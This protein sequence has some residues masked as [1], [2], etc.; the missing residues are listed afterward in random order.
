[1][2]ERELE[3]L[4]DQYSS[5]FLSRVLGRDVD[6]HSKKGIFYIWDHLGDVKIDSLNN[7]HKKTLKGLKAYVS[8]NLRKRQELDLLLPYYRVIRDKIRNTL[9]KGRLVLQKGDDWYVEFW[10]EDV[11]ALGL[12]EKFKLVGVC[13]K[14]HQGFSDRERFKKGLE[15]WF[16]IR[17]CWLED[18]GATYRLRVDL[19]RQS[20]TFV[21]LL[22]QRCRVP[23]S[24]I[25]EIKRVPFKV[26]VR[27]ARHIPRD[28]I[29]WVSTELDE[30]V[31]VRF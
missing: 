2:D 23:E 12:P 10:L 8:R 22:F 3:W 15:K 9:V 27:A 24:D 30:S 13:P 5:E 7:L 1:M 20:T 18:R 16:M 4:I 26:R 31:I 14:R 25:L 19:T 6:V 28:A 17:D 21:K 29:R 11:F